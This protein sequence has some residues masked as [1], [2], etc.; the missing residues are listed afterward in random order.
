MTEYKG[1]SQAEHPKWEGW[2]WLDTY[3]TNQDPKILENDIVLQCMVD[4]YYFK[5]RINAT[6]LTLTIW[7]MVALFAYELT[8]G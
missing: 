5:K 2:Y 7:A 6:L 3:C 4:K 8:K 1:I